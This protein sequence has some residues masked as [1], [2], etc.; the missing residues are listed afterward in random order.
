MDRSVADHTMNAA[1]RAHIGPRKAAHDAKRFALH[2]PRRTC[3]RAHADGVI[4]VERYR[5]PGPFPNVFERDA[6]HQYSQFYVVR[7][8]H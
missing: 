4:E 1:R 7:A 3:K 6:P 2:S 8:P 5:Y